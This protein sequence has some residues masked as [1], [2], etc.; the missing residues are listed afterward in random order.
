MRSVPCFGYDKLGHEGLC[1]IEPQDPP[2]SAAWI[3]DNA[4]LGTRRQDRRVSGAPISGPA[5]G[6]QMG[7]AKAR[8]AYQ[9]KHRISRVSISSHIDLGEVDTVHFFSELVPE[10]SGCVYWSCT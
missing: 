4:H 1:P 10:D 9:L 3:G 6:G 7:F 5:Q 8:K 2:I